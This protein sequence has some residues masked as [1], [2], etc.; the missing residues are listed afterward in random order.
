[1]RHSRMNSLA[2]AG[3][4]LSLF[5]FLLT[6]FSALCLFSVILNPTIGAIAGILGLVASSMGLTMTAIARSEIVQNAQYGDE[7]AVSGMV[8]GIVVC[9]FSVAA[10]VLY[11]VL[12]S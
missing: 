4:A 3:F 11:F 1:M 6:V 2:P 9:V 10:L 7:Y 8:V 5:S 12:F